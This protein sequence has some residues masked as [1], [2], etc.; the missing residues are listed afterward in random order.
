MVRL[1]GTAMLPN[2]AEIERAEARIRRFIPPTPLEHSGRLSSLLGREVYLKLEVFQP[3]HVFKIRGALNKLMQLGDSAL[4]KG[5]VT[6]SSGN[7]GLAIAYASRKFGARAVICVPKNANP[8]KVSL[9]QDQGA[10][11]L[12]FGMGYDQAFEHAL[13]VAERRNLTF[14]HAFNDRDVIAGQGT[15]GLEMVRQLPE[16][17][18]AV[19]AIGGGGLI[20][21]ISIALKQSLDAVRVYGAETRAIPSMYESV[22]AGRMVKVNPKPTIA[23]GMQSAVPGELTFEAVTKYVDR[24]G[25]VNDR[26]IEDAVFDLLTNTGVLAEPAGASPL[27]A[28]KG[29]LRKERTGKTVLVISGGN[30]S[31]ALLA[32]I[33]KRRVK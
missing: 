8:Q 4:K 24:I 13:R 28:V 1:S 23:D 21:G 18:S 30:V 14:V 29:P 20:S 2:L 7:H 26:Q 15:C 12:R 9:I 5:V 22:E 10:E 11:V 27:A 3:I 19:V 31:V 32:R 33:L 6:A 17:D 25:L 16:I